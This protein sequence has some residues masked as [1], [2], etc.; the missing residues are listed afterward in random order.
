MSFQKCNNKVDVD[1]EVE[2]SKVK[3]YGIK[4]GGG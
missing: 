3:I 1:L 2:S 4:R